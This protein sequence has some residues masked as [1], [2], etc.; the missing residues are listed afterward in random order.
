MAKRIFHI[1]FIQLILIFSCQEAT[2]LN[3]NQKAAVRENIQAMAEKF[4]NA[5][6]AHN[7]DAAMAYIDS[8]AAFN[9]VS[10]FNFKI[11]RTDIHYAYK[12]ISSLK[13]EWRTME[14][15]TITTLFA[16]FQGDFHQAGTDSTGKV[17]EISGNISALVTF[18][19]KN[20]KFLKGQIYTK[21][22]K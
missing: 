1:A 8:S 6:D 18:Q 11:S 5:L 13:S 14:I 16:Y 17:N 4:F 7:T 10:F 21:S 22:L 2:Q 3:E 9:Y 12:E 15:D 19:D 20:W